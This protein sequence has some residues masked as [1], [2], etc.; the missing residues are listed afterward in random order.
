MLRKAMYAVVSVATMAAAIAYG[1]TGTVTASLDG[2]AFTVAFANHAHETNSLWV[3][4]GPGDSGLGTNGWAHVERL[5][6]VT[7]GTN[8][9]TYPAPAGWGET[10]KAIRFIL[11]EVPYDYDYSLDFIRSKSRER[12]VL[13]DFDFCVSFIVINFIYFSCHTDYYSY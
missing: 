5:G 9:W 8:A 3:V 1:N 7:P 4:Y 6:T 2:D 12:L 11:S 10:V 13:G